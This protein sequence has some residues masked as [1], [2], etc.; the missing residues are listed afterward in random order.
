MFMSTNNVH[1]WNHNKGKANDRAPTPTDSS[2]E[3]VP[4]LLASVPFHPSSPRPPKPARRT[5]DLLTG[6]ER[7]LG[8][9]DDL[10][11][12]ALAADAR[13]VVRV[14]RLEARLLAHIAVQALVQEVHVE[15][16]IRRVQA[17]GCFS[18]RARACAP[19]ERGP[20]GAVGPPCAEDVLP[21][22]VSSA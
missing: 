5:A 17:R 7:V 1:Q 19:R 11:F 9:L 12:D 13:R 10:Y 21:V 2:S 4:S 16:W 3:S 15:G 6:N 22:C 14:E 8:T 18:V 20:E